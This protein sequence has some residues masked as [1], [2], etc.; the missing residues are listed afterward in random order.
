VQA[1][2]YVLLYLSLAVKN[3]LGRLFMA[4][5]ETSGAGGPAYMRCQGEGICSVSSTNQLSLLLYKRLAPGVLLQNSTGRTKAPLL[6]L[7][8]DAS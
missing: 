3:G 5:E 4:I 8:T 1:Q 7:I 6:H 2:H